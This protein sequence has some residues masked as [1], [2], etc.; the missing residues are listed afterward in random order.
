MKTLSMWS[1]FLE[2]KEPLEK[3]Y[4]NLS[5]APLIILRLSLDENSVLLRIEADLP[6]F[7]QNPPKKWFDKKANTVQVCLDFIECEKIKILEFSRNN[8][9]ILKIKMTKSDNLDFKIK[10]ENNFLISGKCRWLYLQS[11]SAYSNQK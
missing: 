8:N 4:G 5:L 1:K 6:E 3:T 2:N 11:I 7:P 10:G 9:A